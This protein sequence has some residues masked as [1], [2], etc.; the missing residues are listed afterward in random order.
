[1]AAVVLVAG[2]TGGGSETTSGTQRFVAG[3]GVVHY[4]P[5]ANR[6]PGP[7]IAG[8]TLDGERLDVGTLR[9]GGVAVVNIWG[10]WCAPCK[11][12][13]GALERVARATRSRGV[14]FVGINI[15][16]SSKTAARM[17]V[18]KY[19]VTYPSL[20]DPSARLLPRFEIAPKTIPSTYVIDP[21]GRIAAYVYGPIE[22]QP[23]TDLVDR[24]LAEAGPA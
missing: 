10:S 11:K 24:V 2:C 19:D 14:R 16:D 23:L 5:A 12:E 20:Y 6:E 17:H 1:M 22:E 18:T 9:A 15:R 4:V 13:Q 21:G 3:D 7:D 8:E